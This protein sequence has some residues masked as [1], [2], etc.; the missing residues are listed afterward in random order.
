MRGLLGEGSGCEGN[1]SEGSENEGSVR[2]SVS[3]GSVS[4]GSLDHMYVAVRVVCTAVR[5]QCECSVDA[6]AIQIVR[7]P[8]PCNHPPTLKKQRH[9][10]T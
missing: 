3:E 2:G 10:T 6:S 4:E 1:E 8:M 5:V 9:S 7:Q